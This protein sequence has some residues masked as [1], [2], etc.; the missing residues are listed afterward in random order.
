MSEFLL[1]PC[2]EK[3]EQAEKESPL[4]WRTALLL[5]TKKRFGTG[6]PKLGDR[7][8]K[9]MLIPGILGCG[10]QLLTPKLMV[11]ILVITRNARYLYSS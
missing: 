6:T 8:A 10:S 11:A 3:G 4:G 9:P 5:F 7:V 2:Q 1:D